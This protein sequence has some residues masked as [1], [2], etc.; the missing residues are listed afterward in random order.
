MI[1]SHKEYMQKIDR[2]EIKPMLKKILGLVKY[3]NNRIQW[4]EIIRVN[5]AYFS[6]FP[7]TPH[8]RESIIKQF[9]TPA[10]KKLNKLKTKMGAIISGL[11]EAINP[12]Q[13]G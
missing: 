5:V 13:K 11:E 9:E 12:K 8:T 10:E 4:G 1:Y 7:V 2:N 6:T 3:Y